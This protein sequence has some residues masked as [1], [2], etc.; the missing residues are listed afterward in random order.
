MLVQFGLLGLGAVLVLIVSFFKHASRL[1][2]QVGYSLTQGYVSGLIALCI[3][4]IA[5]SLFGINYFTGKEGIWMIVIMLSLLDRFHAFVKEW[6]IQKN[7]NS[8]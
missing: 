6:P 5:G 1:H 3:C 7:L 4:V 2:R 8:E